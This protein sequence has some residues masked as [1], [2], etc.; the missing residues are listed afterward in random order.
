MGFW[1]GKAHGYV[2]ERTNCATVTAESDIETVVEL[3]S[4]GGI[5]LDRCIVVRRAM[6]V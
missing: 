3:S 5:V 6:G 1:S 2:D 4:S